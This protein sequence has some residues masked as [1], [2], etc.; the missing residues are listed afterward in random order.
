MRKLY[1]YIVTYEHAHGSKPNSKHQKTVEAYNAKDACEMILT[2]YWT[3]MD[4]LYYKR[5]TCRNAASYGVRYPFHR[6]AIRVTE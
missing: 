2:E 3:R 6:R 4:E 5:G 1:T